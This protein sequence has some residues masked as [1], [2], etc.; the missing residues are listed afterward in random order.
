MNQQ[1]L[2]LLECYILHSTLFENNETMYHCLHHCNNFTNVFNVTDC[3][4][5]VD[6]QSHMQGSCFTECRSLEFRDL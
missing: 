3:F 2:I 6:L 1:Q 4:R 5:S